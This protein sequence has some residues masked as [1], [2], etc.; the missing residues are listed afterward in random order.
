[1]WIPRANAAP[2]SAG[3]ARARGRGV[4]GPLEFVTASPGDGPGLFRPP[5]GD[6]KGNRPRPPAGPDRAPTRANAAA[7]P[8]AAN[9]EVAKT[10]SRAAVG[11][12]ESAGLTV[13]LISS[14]A[15]ARIGASS[16]RSF[17]QLCLFCPFTCR[18]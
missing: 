14:G 11:T 12:P 8:A 9:D 13:V 2:P 1:V 10:G 6:G 5:F 17:R 3:T 16:C 18:P 7:T 15:R 4:S